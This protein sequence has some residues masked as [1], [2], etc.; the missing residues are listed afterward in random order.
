MVLETMHARK[1][2]MA[3]GCPFC[4]LFLAFCLA[5]PEC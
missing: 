5:N 3:R 2:L 1:A 4:F